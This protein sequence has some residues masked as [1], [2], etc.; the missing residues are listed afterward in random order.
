[1]CANGCAFSMAPISAWKSR[2]AWARAP[3]FEL[4]FRN[5][6]QPCRRPCGGSEK[7]IGLASEPSEIVRCEYVSLREVSSFKQKW[8]AESLCKRVRKTVTEIELRRAAAL[9]KLGPCLTSG[10]GLLLGNWV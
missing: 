10:I 5:L 6:S 3:S 1:M 8:L 2:V 4:M 7:R 9:A